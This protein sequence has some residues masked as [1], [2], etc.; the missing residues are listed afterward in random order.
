MRRLFIWLDA[1]ARLRA[2]R[3][4]A[5]R[6]QS[7][8][9]K[10]RRFGRGS[11]AADSILVPVSA[12]GSRSLELVLPAVPASVSHARRAVVSLLDHLDVDLWPVQTAVTE[13]VANAVVHAYPDRAPGQVRLQAW[14]EDLLLTIVV[15]DDGVGMSSGR[16]SQG[17]GEGMAVIRRLAREVEVQ[18]RS[19]TRLVMRLWLGGEAL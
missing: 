3:L 5:A 19:G 10:S 6:R 7:G 14:L 17:L 13:A 16:D 15:A 2:R 11:W 4:V 18:S 9:P 8:C 12:P 1:A